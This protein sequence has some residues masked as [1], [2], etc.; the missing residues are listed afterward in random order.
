MEPN[1][2]IYFFPSD[3]GIH[4]IRKLGFSLFIIEVSMIPIPG[5]GPLSFQVAMLWSTLSVTQLVNPFFR[6]INNQSFILRHENWPLCRWTSSY[7]LGLSNLELSV[8]K[9][10]DP[11]V[12]LT[13]NP[14]PKNK[15][16]KTLFGSITF[17]RN[18]PKE[19]SFRLLLLKYSISNFEDCGKR[20]FPISISV[21]DG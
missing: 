13:S 21:L 18:R 9:F 15:R 19:A 14:Y 2:P 5:N 11:V 4:L 7:K 20:S 6:F 17:S 12:W 10:F 1:L 16:G 3:F 8:N